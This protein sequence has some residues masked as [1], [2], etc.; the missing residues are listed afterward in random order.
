MSLRLQ[1]LVKRGGLGVR[2]TTSVVRGTHVSRCKGE[3]NGGGC[4]VAAA[5]T[6]EE[7]A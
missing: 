1:L 2:G 3:D 6:D 5:N 7:V 4:L